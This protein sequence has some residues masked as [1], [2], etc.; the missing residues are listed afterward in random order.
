MRAD[1]ASIPLPQSRQNSDPASNPLPQPR[2]NS[3][4][5]SNPFPEPWSVNL[6]K[7]PMLVPLLRPIELQHS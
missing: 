5:A 1:P 7:C 3:V 6:V 4:P 2:Q